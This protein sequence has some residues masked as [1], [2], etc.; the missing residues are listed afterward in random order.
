[1]HLFND[2]DVIKAGYWDVMVVSGSEGR[3]DEEKKWIMKL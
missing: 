2:P 3:F 1:M